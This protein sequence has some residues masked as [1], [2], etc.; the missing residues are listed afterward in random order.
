MKRLFSVL[1]AITLL[2]SVSAGTT[3]LA[4]DTN[5]SALYKLED[6]TLHSTM[7]TVTG[8][9]P[10]ITNISDKDFDTQITGI[11]DG[12]F[13]K[14]M[15]SANPGEA[16]YPPVNFS[17]ETFSNEKYFSIVL[18]GSV[19][20]LNTGSTV[21]QTIVLDQKSYKL[22]A[23]TDILG[24]SANGVSEKFISADMKNNPDK[25]LKDTVPPEVTPAT[26]FYM[27][28]D[29][30]LVFIFDKYAITP[31]FEGTPRLV[32]P[33][34][35]YMHIGLPLE[36]TYLN[37]KIRMV[38]LRKVLEMF[39][40]PVYWNST[41]STAVVRAG[42]ESCSLKVGLNDYNGKELP[43]A[44]EIKYGRTYVP[45]E[46]IEEYCGISFSVSGN[47]LVLSKLLNQDTKLIAGTIKDATMNTVTIATDSG[48]TLSFSTVNADKTEC[49]GLLIGSKVDIYYTG[50]I[51]DT[52][53]AKADV[54][55]MKQPVT[56]TEQKID[57]NTPVR[58]T[59]T[60][61]DAAMNTI[62]IKAEDGREL[63][64]VTDNADKFNC[65]GLLIG[66]KV[67]IFYIGAID[68]TDTSKVIV[69]YM[70]Q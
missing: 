13:N 65:D 21:V 20:H 70:E 62:K 11:I 12:F 66:S 52:D 4:A 60:I 39:H 68:G 24:P 53:T 18:F 61:L 40:V 2:V 57:P 15:Q 33:M 26:P 55:C 28:N 48:A 50:A 56:D 44:P 35:D 25:Y 43:I 37:G 38:P 47:N 30:N 17:Y 67:D 64:F 54:I 7:N 31:G 58:V 51:N 3:A 49:T 32:F 46:F 19:N 23:L 8:T 42:G 10:K 36:N 1:T 22:Y 45:I 59:G 34:K 5:I 41:T 63:S 9:L 16:P 14:V 27:D 29:S 69:T 6:Q